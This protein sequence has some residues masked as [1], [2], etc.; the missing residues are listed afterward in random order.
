MSQPRI[1]LVRDFDGFD[2]AGYDRA[3]YDEDG[4][5]RITCTHCKRSLTRAEARDAVRCDAG[6]FCGQCADEEIVSCGLCHGSGG[7]PEY[8]CRR[9]GGSGGSATP[10]QLAREE[11][12]DDEKD[13]DI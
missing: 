3:G 8:P 7:I 6:D 9:C 11:S 4:E 10:R 1:N 12:G 2:A 13:T 5:P